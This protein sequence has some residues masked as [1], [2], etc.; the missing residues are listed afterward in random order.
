MTLKI[1]IIGANGLLGNLL[2]KKIKYT[3]NVIGTT[4]RNKKKSFIKCDIKNKEQVFKTIQKINPNIIVHLA[5]ITGNLECEKDPEKT[6]ETNVM[7]TYYILE[8]IKDKKIRLIFSSSREVYGNS[9]HKVDENHCLNPNSLNGITKMISENLI[10]NYHYKQKIPF[11][12]LRFTNFYGENNEKRGISKMIKTSLSDKKIT[13]F[14]GNQYIDLIH[15]DD[16]VNAIIKMIE[17]KKDGIYNIGFGKSIKLLSLIKILENVSNI[18]INFKIAKSRDTDTQKISV[19]VLKA[20][21]ELGF[22]AK[23]TPKITINRMV[24]K[25]LKN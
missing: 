8:A 12:I 17:K 16:A 18:K 19:N 24:T 2:F 7:G 23:I 11:N 3:Y 15:F 13:I 9:N 4:N 20:K 22:E 25:W 1:L 5:G 10:M 21:K 14:G 6:L